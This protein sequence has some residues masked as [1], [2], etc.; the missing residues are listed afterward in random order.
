MLALCY[1]FDMEDTSS[2]VAT[3]RDEVHTIPLVELETQ[4]LQAGIVMSRRQITRHC[5]SGT[6]DAIKLPAANN[7]ENWYIAQGSIEKGIADIK[8]LRS[9]RDSHVETRRDM[10]DHVPPAEPLK[11]DIDTSGHDATRRDMSDQQTSPASDATRLDTSRRVETYDIFEHPYVKRLE[12]QVEKW[13]GKYHDQVRR[14]EEIQMKGTQQILELQRMTAIGQSETLADFMLKA[15]EWILGPGG[16]GI[17]EKPA[18][19][20]GPAA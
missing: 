11:T 4:I 13:E 14:T 6:F 18:T 1:S 19:S 20:E 2:H 10:S 8:A 17:P 12:G 15:K 3:R 5:K 9:L 7:V 16:A